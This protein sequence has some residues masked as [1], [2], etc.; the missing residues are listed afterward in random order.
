MKI[1]PHTKK[2]VISFFL[3]RVQVHHPN[4]KGREVDRHTNRVVSLHLL[5]IECRVPI[6][7][8]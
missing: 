7:L 1:L 5:V 3:R 2:T 8:V 4:S 6:L